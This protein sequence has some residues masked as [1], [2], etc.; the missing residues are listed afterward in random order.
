MLVNINPSYRPSE[1][2]Y[3][4]KKVRVVRVAYVA[5]VKGMLRSC[6]WAVGWPWD[7]AHNP[8]SL[9]CFCQVGCRALVMSAGYKTSDFDSMIR[10]LIPRL[11]SCKVCSCG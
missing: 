6:P 4:L 10:G 8:P 5:C 9:R 1:L 3:S 11:D 2:A 7:R